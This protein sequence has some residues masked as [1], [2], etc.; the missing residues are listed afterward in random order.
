MQA[1]ETRFTETVA[2][3]NSIPTP[4]EN[5][6]SGSIGKFEPHLFHQYLYRCSR[7][8]GPICKIHMWRRP[9]VII[10]DNEARAYVMKNRPDLF[11]RSSQ[12]ESVFKSIEINGVFTSDG[13]EWELHRKMLNPAFKPSNIQRFFNTILDVS[14]RLCAVLEKHKAPFDFQNLI[15]R[16]TVDVTTTLSFGKDINTLENPDN[17][18]QKDL[19]NL[20]PAIGRRMKSPFPYWKF[21]T[22]KE[23]RALHASINRMKCNV[24][25]FIEDARR[26]LGAS[27]TPNNILQA[28]LLSPDVKEED[29]FGN[30]ITLL[31]AGEDTTAN[32]IAWTMNYLVDR[33]ELMSEAQLEVDSNYPQNRDLSW[34]DLDRFP[35]TFSLA[36]EAMRLKPVT[37]FVHA[38]G[39]KDTNLLG[40]HIPK[41]TLMMLNNVQGGFDKSHF[42]NPE[43]YNPKRWLTLERQKMNAYNQ[44]VNP[45]GAGTR[46][47][48]GRQL[49]NVEIKIV[50]ILLLK[51]FTFLRPAGHA[52]STEYLS[53]TMTPKDLVLQCSSRG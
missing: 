13:Q 7:E 9:I 3:F 38:E 28:M 31:I 25:L 15:Q 36:Q 41:G 35:L 33:P 5:W 43:E 46:M 50:L 42:E 37:P 11:L 27:T 30:V 44:T 40:Y 2:P 53:M 51:R 21:I 22:T 49:A 32:S 18:I 14:S 20:I 34:E 1:N 26:Q 8:L 45:F 47:C 23:D 4:N 10:S 12:L 39:R 48:P 16:Y 29:I 17:E 6:L 24:R 19:A 52:S